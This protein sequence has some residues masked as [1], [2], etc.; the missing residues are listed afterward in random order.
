MARKIALAIAGMGAVAAAMTLSL[1]TPSSMDAQ[2]TG[3]ALPAFEVASIKTDPVSSDYVGTNIDMHLVG[4][5][6]IATGVTAKYLVQ[7]AYNVE[8]FQLSG[9]PSWINSD[10][11]DI[12]AKVEDSLLAEWQKL[13]ASQR[14]QQEEQ[15][16]LMF[17]S[18]LADRFH[19]QVSHEKK[20]LP[21]YAL[22]AAK[23][24][25]KFRLAKDAPETPEGPGSH[26][27]SNNGGPFV[28]IE[29]DIPISAFVKIIERQPELGGRLVLDETGLKDR[30]SFTLKWT[31]QRMTAN[32]GQETGSPPADPSAPSVWTALQEQLGLRLE[33]TKGPV[34]TIVID[35][36]EEPSPN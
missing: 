22:V 1:T 25:P 26:V 15:I 10:K 30:Y 33:S 16:K 20:E 32:G 3:A 2:A 4:S 14:D 11:Y 27:S 19:L 36:I 31:R 13:P 12:D 7:F 21:I 24:G 5:H 8:E 35:H 29:N 34:D 28:A 17:Q 6:Y 23:N 18:L 9:G